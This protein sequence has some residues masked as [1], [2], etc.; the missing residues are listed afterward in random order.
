[1]MTPGSSSE[2]KSETKEPELTVQE[3]DLLSYS[4]K[5]TRKVIL[6]T[7]FKEI[8]DLCHDEIELLEIPQHDG[9]PQKYL[10]LPKKMTG[11]TK[12]VSLISLDQF[13][14]EL[15]KFKNDLERLER[16]KKIYLSQLKPNAMLKLPKGGFVSVK[17]TEVHREALAFHIS[18]L[19]GFNTSNA[20]MISHAGTPVLFIQFSEIEL[21]NEFA[22]GKK[23]IAT[24]ERTEYCNYSTITP[25]GEGLTA[26]Q[27]IDDFG[28]AFAFFYLCNDPDTIGGY[29]K[30]K[31]LLNSKELFILD[32]VLMGDPNFKLDSRVNLVAL[33]PSSRHTEGR[34]K[35]LFEDSS[36]EEKIKSLIT[37][38]KNKTS[39][40]A[41]MDLVID[42]YEQAIKSADKTTQADLETFKKDA[43]NLKKLIKE[44]ITEIFTI[45]PKF[46]GNNIT[47]ENAQDA[48]L[49]IP[50][51]ILEKVI[52]NPRLFTDDGRP[53]KHPWTDVNNIKIMNV[54]MTESTVTLELNS[55]ADIK[56][57]HA[58]F[59]KAGIDTKKALSPADNFKTITL[60]IEEYTKL[61]EDLFF[62]ENAKTF[63][64]NA[65]YLTKYELSIM[66]NTDGKLKD[67][68][69]EL[70]DTNYLKTIDS[71]ANDTVKIDIMK[72][73]LKQLKTFLAE[74]IKD[75][76]FVKHVQKKLHFEIQKQLQ[77]MV[78][79]PDVQTLMTRAFNAA[80]KL[81]RIAIFNE[82]VMQAIIT[83]NINSESF[84]LYLQ[85]CDDIAGQATNYTSSKDCSQTFLSESN[86]LLQTLAPVKFHVVTDEDETKV[87]EA[88][89]PQSM[90]M[91]ETEKR[92]KAS[93]TALPAIS[94]VSSNT[95]D[96]PKLA[97]NQD[98]PA[99]L[100]TT[101]TTKK[102]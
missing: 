96:S 52:N 60:S 46:N 70:I 84:N 36:L 100:P 11:V 93:A 35:T 14:L 22:R 80:I 86:L 54:K 79:N 64:P 27:C 55:Q 57:L 73:T 102:E 75:N 65:I 97:A 78:N 34:N 1:M 2:Q 32:Q 83:N 3:L 77:Q 71:A 10:I 76:G 101:R 56:L 16:E 29:N 53:Y 69:V 59:Q 89:P 92:D 68:I 15:I 85:M 74:P 24:F 25:V 6:P 45:F 99:S 42:S 8:Q 31:A 44:R 48:K 41:M 67:W 47:A 12:K 91:T 21:L 26:D 72:H 88:S 94:L 33:H 98:T 28:K 90:S 37:L 4:T 40:L 82:V 87:S 5:Q 23:E 7:E 19:L 50:A 63:N 81:D 66:P 18:R 95:P 9:P 30:N 62:P 17:K 51:L 39:I 49:L 20:S 13:M 43:N 61:N 58:Y 38:T